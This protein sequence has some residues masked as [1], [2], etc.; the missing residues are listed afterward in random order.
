MKIKEIEHRTIIVVT[1]E[2]GTEYTRHSEDC[3]MQSYGM[4]EECVQD[5]TEIEEAY[6]DFIKPTE[7][8]I[9]FNL[10]GEHL[11]RSIVLSNELVKFFDDKVKNFDKEM[12]QYSDLPDKE[13][14]KMEKQVRKAF[15][16]IEQDFIT[17][18]QEANRKLDEEFM[19][20]G[21]NPRMSVDEFSKLMGD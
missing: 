12:E 10:M 3:W 17:Q 4:S 8:D 18:N 16:K 5:T 20:R 7:E 21:Y 6:Q 11:D 13:Y 2:D 15:D 9:Q 1:T 14:R 19:A